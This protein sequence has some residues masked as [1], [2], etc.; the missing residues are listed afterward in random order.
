MQQLEQGGGGLIVLHSFELQ[1]MIVVL[2]LNVTTDKLRSLLKN[3]SIRFAEKFI[4]QKHASFL[5]P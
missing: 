4:I 1:C 5:R 2:S 3:I